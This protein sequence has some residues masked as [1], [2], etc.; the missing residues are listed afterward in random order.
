M[1]RK[2][3]LKK[4]RHDANKWCVDC[5]HKDSCS[6]RKDAAP[7]LLDELRETMKGKLPCLP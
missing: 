1:G 4:V 2:S 5:E 7:S 6:R 3:R